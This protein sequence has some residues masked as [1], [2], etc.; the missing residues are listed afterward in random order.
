MIAW[1]GVLGVKGSKRAER[2][3][4]IALQRFQAVGKYENI[5]WEL[6]DS[7]M[8]GKRGIVNIE[9]VLIL[10]MNSESIL[11]L[12]AYWLRTCCEMLANWKQPACS[13]GNVH[14]ICF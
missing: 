13:Y 10:S 12:F 11:K 7:R 8:F 14:E 6:H 2:I 4:Q 1:Y 9:Q 3:S 5:S